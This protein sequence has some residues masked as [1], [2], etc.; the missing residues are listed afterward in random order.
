[1]REPN[2]NH[3]L[4]QVYALMMDALDGQ[5]PAGDWTRLEAALRAHPDLA[6]EWE[7]MQAVDTLFR[8]APAARP[9]ADFAE[10]TMARL[11]NWRVR[12]WAMGAVFVAMGAAGLLPL[13]FVG[14]FFG[15]QL[16]TIATAT[17]QISGALLGA[18]GQL[19]VH[20]GG[21]LTRYPAAMGTL[22]VMIG[23]ISLWSGVYRQLMIAPATTAQS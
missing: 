5:L 7:A 12:R 22:L 18:L 21:F 13:A 9:A 14:W 16:T 11:P 23:S 15:A 2:E 6:V 8:R 1:M 10:R 3:D 17:W 20:F 19:L 4:D